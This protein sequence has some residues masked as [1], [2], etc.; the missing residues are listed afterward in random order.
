[1]FPTTYTKNVRNRNHAGVRSRGPPGG[2]YAFGPPKSFG[3][4]GL[5]WLLWRSPLHPEGN[6]DFFAHVVFSFRC[7]EWRSPLHPEG[8]CDILP[9]GPRGFQSLGGDLRYTP[10]GIATF[11][12][13]WWWR[14]FFCSCGDLRYTPRGIATVCEHFGDCSSKWVEISATP[15]GELRH[16]L[17]CGF[18]ASCP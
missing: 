11:L 9:P 10:R 7:V 16:P 5:H 14:W 2:H 1:M 8:N 13:R 18:R 4:C 17:W 3:F 6:C 12:G 15:R